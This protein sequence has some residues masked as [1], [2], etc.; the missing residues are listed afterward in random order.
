M[1]NLNILISLLV[2]GATIALFFLL[3]PEEKQLLFYVNLGLSLLIEGGV[4]AALFITESRYNLQNIATSGPIL[5][6]AG[7]AVLWMLIYNLLMHPDVDV[8]WYY[9]GL[10]V[11]AVVCALSAI[12]TKQGGS[13][14]RRVNED[15]KNAVVA[16]NVIS[17]DVRMLKSDLEDALRTHTVD[18]ELRRACFRQLQ[19]FIDK[20]VVMPAFDLQRNQLLADTI[21]KG[22]EQIQ[23]S[24]AEINAAST[25]AEAEKTLALITTQAKSIVSKM[26]IL[27]K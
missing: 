15:T 22:I 24:I 1:K 21:A 7:I 26:E 4:L 6:G 19:L 12:F 3:G 5:Y 2:V 14:Q 8:K 11:I 16:R 20:T 10:I 27:K 9:A 25:Q 13:V 23:R 18:A 17:L